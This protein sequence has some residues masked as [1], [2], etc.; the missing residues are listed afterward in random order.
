MPVLKNRPYVENSNDSAWLTNADRPLTGYERVFGTIATPRSMRTR[1]AIEDVASMA[2]KGRLKVSDLQRQQFANRAPAGELAASEV[3]K[4]CAALPGGTAVGTGG[5]P[6]DVSDACTVLR[7]WDR[8]VDSDSRGALLF[9]R[10]WR[11][12]SAVPAA[13]LWKTPFDPADPVRTPR[14]LNT[15]APG[16]GRALADAVA[17]LRAAGIALDAP[18]GKHQFVVRDGKRLPIGGGTESLG[19]WNKTEPVWNAA[20]GGY[21]EVSSGSSYIQA[22]GWD[23][24]HCPVAR[25]L[26]TYSQSENPKSPHSSDQT[27]LYA[28]ERWVTSGSARRT[29][30]ARRSCGWCGAR[31]AVAHVREGRAARTPLPQ[32]AARSGYGG[33]SPPYVSRSRRVR[34]VPSGSRG[35][36]AMEPGSGTVRNRRAAPRSG[37]SRRRERPAARGHRL[38]RRPSPLGPRG[39]G[40]TSC[41]SDWRQSLIEGRL[42]SDPGPACGH[43][44]GRSGIRRRVRR[45][46]RGRARWRACAGRSRPGAR[47]R[48]PKRLAEGRDA[49]ADGHGAGGDDLAVDHAVA[50]EAS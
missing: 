29:S 6:V 40:S 48:V 44:W 16:V 25:T 12:A 22:V 38:V 11:K 42:R 49:V 10:F 3:A 1:G 31:A 15:A 14:D 45:I 39:R 46:P 5:T 35:M 36:A 43:V 27:R 7:R 8:S 13:E 9:D 41:R 23:D 32:P 34:N 37:G 30:H 33:R 4:W 28:G 2:D 17:E 26:L 19:I 24:S 21:T 50:F 47:R 20:G 18:L